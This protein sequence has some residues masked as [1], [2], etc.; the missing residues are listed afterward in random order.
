MCRKDKDNMH[1]LTFCDSY[2]HINS[3]LRINDLYSDATDD[4]CRATKAI[5]ERTEHIEQT[6]PRWK[7]S[8]TPEIGEGKKE[9]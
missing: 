9:R 1:H 7:S 3:R 2:R 6:D 4:I 5:R 8:E